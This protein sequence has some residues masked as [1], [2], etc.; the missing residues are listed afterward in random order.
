MRLTREAR[1][2]WEERADYLRR[3]AAATGNPWLLYEAAKLE[4]S[5]MSGEEAEAY[6]RK[7]ADELEI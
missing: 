7:I 5:H 3:R 6:R 2:S 4:A 1:A